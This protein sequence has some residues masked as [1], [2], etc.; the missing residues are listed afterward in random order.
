ME[1]L[2]I[3][4]DFFNDPKLKTTADLKR[5]KYS[6]RI[7]EILEQQIQP[8]Y[9]YDF[10]GKPIVIFKAFD[11]NDS[12][13]IDEFIRKIRNFNESPVVFIVLPNEI[14]IYNGY[15]F[16]RSRKNIIK[17][18]ITSLNDSIFDNLKKLDIISGGI[19]KP[20]NP[21]SEYYYN[22]KRVDEQLL[23]NLEVARELLIESG[24]EEVYA[25]NLLGRCL[26]VQYLIDRKAL[27]N[28]PNREAFLEI[29]KNKTSLYQLFD[30]LKQKFNGDMFPVTPEEYSE[31]TPKHLRILDRLFSSE[32]LSTG[33]LS[34]FD[35]YD[36]SIIPVELISNIYER[37]LSKKSKQENKA[38]Y[39]PLFLVDY[40]LCQT[41]DEILE[42]KNSLDIKIMDPSCGSGIF[43]VECFRRLY[44]A[45]YDKN[46]NATKET[47]AEI[48][49]S[50]LQNCIYG[51]DITEA[52]IDVAIFSLYIATLDYLEPKDIE[53]NGFIFPV[54]KNRT[55]YVSDIFN[56]KNEFNHVFK[57]IHFDLILGNPPWGT[58]KE[59]KLYIKYCNKNNIQISDRQ[60]A[61][62]FLFRSADFA[63]ETT[64]IALVVTSKIIYN[65]N[66]E[67]FRRQYLNAFCIEGYLDFSFS[68]NFKIFTSLASGCVFFYKKAN[69]DIISKNNIQHLVLRPNIFLEYLN[70]FALEKNDIKLISQQLLIDNDWAWKVFLYGNVLDFHFMK[71]LFSDKDNFCSLD[72][73]LAENKVFSGAGFIRGKKDRKY[74]IDIL[75]QYKV[76][77]T[78][79]NQNKFYRFF[80]DIDNLKYFS[81]I[82]HEDDYFHDLGRIEAYKAPHLLVKRGINNISTVAYT[83]VDCAFT[84]SVYGFSTSIN[85]ILLLKY[86][87]SLFSIKVFP[88]L[89][90]MLSSQWGI[91]RGE[92]ILNDYRIALVP[93]KVESNILIKIAEK[94]DEISATCK[95]NSQSFF[96]NGDILINDFLAEMNAI[97]ADLYGIENTEKDLIDFTVNIL[98]PAYRSMEK[99]METYSSPDELRVY[100][101]IFLET[102]NA[103]LEKQGK[104][105]RAEVFN[106]N[107]FTAVNFIFER[108]ISHPSFICR[109]DLEV[110]KILNKLGNLS[111]SNIGSLFVHKEIRGFQD[112]S[113]YI[114]KTNERRNWHPAIARLDISE[115]MESIHQNELGRNAL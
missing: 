16:D 8:D 114:I 48:L 95:K 55:L 41:L 43:L 101:N 59:Q 52:S 81:D 70:I 110:Q 115:I 38:F 30:Y 15:L 35:M 113:F 49:K 7:V 12:D 3:H 23:K 105:L 9:F 86:L 106:S 2:L 45:W 51:V 46:P 77:E 32:E 20:Q 63:D 61:Q 27:S 107:Y 57:N 25:N 56:E 72:N 11:F 109:D 97:F 80:I 94:F 104:S 14:K 33:Q 19:F 17:E 53:S 69:K 102:F 6:R 73:F 84:N 64:E 79:K 44:S 90:F 65:S 62:A 60:I 31:V 5:I 13:Q 91:E 71:R 47:S 34:L 67:E 74:K 26:F 4:L 10:N 85:N 112:D 76:V 88:Y 28:I 98:I 89:I 111:L 100:C 58:P 78:V 21:I 42:H 99:R 1:Q 22:C 18:R 108:G 54:M 87:G 103:L 92:A 93:K 68:A 66:A 39:T 40:I 75:R 83:D 82:Y 37:F 96:F 29:V 50:I 24:L 36:F